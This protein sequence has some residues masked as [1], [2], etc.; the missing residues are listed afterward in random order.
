MYTVYNFL[1]LFFNQNQSLRDNLFRMGKK[2][3]ISEKNKKI[4]ETHSK[5]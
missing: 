5:C 3:S 2:M 4:T 1:F